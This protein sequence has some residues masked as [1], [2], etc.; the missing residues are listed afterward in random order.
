MKISAVL[1]FLLNFD[2][3]FHFQCQF[4]CN[5]KVYITKCNILNS[6]IELQTE[7]FIENCMSLWIMGE[8]NFHTKGDTTEDSLIL[9]YWL[10]CKTWQKNVIAGVT[11][12]SLTLPLRRRRHASR[13]KSYFRDNR[14]R[15]DRTFNFF[16]LKCL[17]RHHSMR[18]IY[19][20]MLLQ[21]VSKVQKPDPPVF[22]CCA[23]LLY[24]ANESNST[25]L[26]LYEEGFQL[27]YQHKLTWLQQMGVNSFCVISWAT[28][29]DDSHNIDFTQSKGLL[30]DSKESASSWSLITCKHISV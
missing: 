14:E 7:V 5:F 22:F 6:M 16:C 19:K 10:P 23:L 27:K 2:F 13:P 12:M 1:Q 28:W 21:N 9:I 3:S 29:S 30:E 24:G 17:W 4:D 15:S 20:T 26:S 18:C 11:L 8:R 25:W